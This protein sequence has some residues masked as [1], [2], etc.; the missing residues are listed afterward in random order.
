MNKSFKVALAVGALTVAGGAFGAA[1]TTFAVTTNVVATCQVTASAMSFANFVP[2][3]PDVDQTSTI[4]V[5]CTTG[6]T[7][8][9]GLGAGNFAAATTSTRRMT[10]TP[11]GALSYSLFSDSTRTTNWGD[12]ILT[13]TVA[14]TGTG[15]GAGND[16]TVYGR[17]P[18]IVA[19]E[20]AP[21]GSYL[22]TVGVTVT[23]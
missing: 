10:G 6:T 13:D 17:I 16:H 2:G 12:V 8:D 1:T 4:N 9:V 22:D 11:A 23:Y 21:V 18:N 15:M 20:T 3:G 7:Y 5:K 19:N 14:G